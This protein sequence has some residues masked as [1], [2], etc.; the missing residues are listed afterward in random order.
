VPDLQPLLDRSRALVAPLRYGAGMKGKVTQSLAAGLPVVTTPIGA[1]G[2][3]AVDGRDM[4]IAEDP[5]AFAD[6][7]VR[8]Y[9]DPDLWARLS[10]GGRS[11]VERVC[12]T[13]TMRER[14]AEL[15]AIAG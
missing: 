8:L 7:I 10:S 5:A 14:V 13:A 11:V 3:G 15:L 12:S 6:A 1:Q 2:L 9:R 4:L